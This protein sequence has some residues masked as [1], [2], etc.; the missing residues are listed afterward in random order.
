MELYG[1]ELV[2]ESNTQEKANEKYEIRLPDLAHVG[3]FI[4]VIKSSNRVI[5]TRN[6]KL[7][8]S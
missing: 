1:R 5:W 4:Q 7:V 3:I 8:L 6:L 2:V